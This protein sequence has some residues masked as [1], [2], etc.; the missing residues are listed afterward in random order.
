MDFILPP[1]GIQPQD[2]YLL[3]LWGFE[4]TGLND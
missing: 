4:D 3:Y 2:P 1:V